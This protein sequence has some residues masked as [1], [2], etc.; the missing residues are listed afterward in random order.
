MFIVDTYGG[1]LNNFSRI[2]NNTLSK[3]NILSQVSY[4][5]PPVE[6]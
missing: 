6:N 4:G 3:K 2:L 5:I 1:I